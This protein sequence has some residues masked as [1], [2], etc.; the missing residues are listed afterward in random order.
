MGALVFRGAEVYHNGRFQRLEVRADG[1]HISQIRPTVDCDGARVIDADGL[2]LMPGVVDP[3]VHFRDPGAT[4]KED[5]E[6]GSRACLRG[7]VTAF[8][9][10]PNTRPSAVNQREIDHKHALA[11]KKSRVHYGFFVGATNDNLADLQTVRRVCGIKIFMGAST[12]DLLVDDPKAL[13]RIFAETAKDR[14]IA[15]HCEDEARIRERTQAFKHRLDA[16]VHSEVRDGEAAWLATEI[17]V[18]LARKYGH[19]AHILHVSTARETELFRPRDRLVTAETS[20][21][22]LLLNVG[23][24][25][26][27]GTLAKM[28]PSLKTEADNRGLWQALRDGRIGCIA[29]DHAPHLLAEKRRDIWS[30]PAGIPAIENSLSLILDAAARGLCRYEQVAR[31]MCEAPAEIYAMKR[32]GRIEIGYDA[33]LVLVDPKARH[34]VRNEEQL[35]R[36][37]WS[38]WHGATL[39]GQPVM[40][41]VRGRVGYEDGEVC[42]N[43]R[44]AEIEFAS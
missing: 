6:S 5:L 24:C 17:A 25:D 32:K 19:R 10:M 22:H 23:D 14:V 3:Q 31:W 11:A 30:A 26:E 9:D 29:T 8:L 1:P 18:G 43:V 35:T 36:C 40:T 44:G 42:D 7:G 39:T 2:L 12:G 15:L 4:H 41:V 38:P 37:G 20:P 13:E 33:D 16:R 28:N 27:L 34:T 21:H